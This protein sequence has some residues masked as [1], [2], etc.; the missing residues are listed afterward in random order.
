MA[1]DIEIHGQ[2]IAAVNAHRIRGD[3]QQRLRGVQ[4]GDRGFLDT[5]DPLIDQPGGA[6][7]QPARRLRLD[8]QIYEQ[9]A[10]RLE[11]ADLLAEL[12]PLLGIVDRIT[13]DRKGW[14][15]KAR[16]G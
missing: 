12:L 7:D 1:L 4:I 6:I 8:V 13:D 10:D 3:L 11:F 15:R 9:V 5:A 2:A 16:R 14:P